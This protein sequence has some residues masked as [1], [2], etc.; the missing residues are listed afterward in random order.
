MSLERLRAHV[1]TVRCEAHAS[2]SSTRAARRCQRFSLSELA[3]LRARAK[4]R[5]ARRLPISVARPDHP[6]SLVALQSV[7]P[8][9]NHL[10]QRCQPSCAPAVGTDEASRSAILLLLQQPVNS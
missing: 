9:L 5:I 1:G 7:S 8:H 6:G 3:Q 2:I 10:K 4:V